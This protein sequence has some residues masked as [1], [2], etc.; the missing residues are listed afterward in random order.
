M[1]NQAQPGFDLGEC[2][3]ES[4]LLRYVYRLVYFAAAGRSLRF[5]HCSSNS[6]VHVS[7]LIL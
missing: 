5:V 3:A 4:R 7:P 6:V 2:E 1:V